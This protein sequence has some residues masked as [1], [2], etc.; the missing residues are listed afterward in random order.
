[1]S[2]KTAHGARSLEE[3]NRYKGAYRAEGRARMRCAHLNKT[4]QADGNSIE[5]GGCRRIV[6]FLRLPKRKST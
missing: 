1:M 5:C 2:R 3:E 6:G 4:L